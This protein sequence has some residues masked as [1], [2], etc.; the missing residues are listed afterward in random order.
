MGE[1][2]ASG[3]KPEPLGRKDSHGEMGG[4]TLGPWL[5]RVSAPLLGREFLNE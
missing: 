2:V 1:E 5:P 3:E 4:Q